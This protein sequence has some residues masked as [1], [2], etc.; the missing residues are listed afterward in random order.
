MRWVNQARRFACVAQ[1]RS[2]RKLLGLKVAPTKAEVRAAFLAAA[3]RHHPD[4]AGARHSAAADFGRLR[5]C[6][7]IVSAC[8]CVGSRIEHG[9]DN[10]HEDAI[11]AGAWETVPTTPS[12]RRKVPSA[13]VVNW[14]AARAAGIGLGEK[15]PDLLEVAVVLPVEPAKGDMAQGLP[16]FLWAAAAA[17]NE[18]GQ[19]TQQQG[20]EFCGVYRRTRDFNAAPAYVHSNKRFHLFWSQMFNDWK[21]G[22]RLAEKAVCSAFFE[23]SRDAPPW[24]ANATT[25]LRWTIWNPKEQCFSS[26]ALTVSSA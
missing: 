12:K 18:N 3:W 25:P 1:C 14:A 6:Y 13:Q 7:E 15:V 23:G 19:P 26:Q 24:E 16:P 20:P 2:C 8:S 11:K 9:T 5:D 22:Q 17:V 4:S 21:I 10:T